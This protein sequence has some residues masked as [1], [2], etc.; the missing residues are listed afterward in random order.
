VGIEAVEVSSLENPVVVTGVSKRYAGADRDAVSDVS[1]EVRPGEVFALLGPN[2]AG[3][4]T[5]V[6]MLA[7]FRSP[8][9]GS[10]RVLGLDPTNRGDLRQLRRR[11][12]VV[13]QQSGFPRYLTVGETLRM[14][15]SYHDDVRDCSETLEVVGLAEKADSLVRSLSGGQQRRLDVAAAL[16]GK[17]EFIF[18]DEP[19][20]GFDPAARRR[21]WD[22][23]SGLRNIGTSVLLTTHYMDEAQALAD[24]VA[25][26]SRGVIAGVGTPTELA[27]QLQLRSTIKFRLPDG[28]DLES[29]PRLAAPVQTDRDGVVTLAADNPT[30]A[31]A[32]LC[33]WAV[34]RG[35]ELDDLTVAPPQLE[36]MYLALAGEAPS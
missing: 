29:L 36:D 27:A 16:V 10:L 3:K 26:M 7:G 25:V 28:A 34:G 4:T 5:L 31:L 14:I 9:S 1:L 21:A 15:A 23:V 30:Q 22:L 20:T 24:R 11:T 13:L 32:E 12:A 8:T 6:E 19:T 18:L 33:Q 2:G 35:V 17:P